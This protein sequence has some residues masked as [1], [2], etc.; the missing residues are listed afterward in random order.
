MREGLRVRILDRGVRGGALYRAKG[1]VVRVSERSGRVYV[2]PDVDADASRRGD[3]PAT[4][5]AAMS[6]GPGKA[7][8]VGIDRE[9]DL[10]TLVPAVGG[11]VCIVRGPYAGEVGTVAWR[12]GD[13]AQADVRVRV[14]GGGGGGGEE[15][16]RRGLSFDDICEV[17]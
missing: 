9:R 8:P 15:R 6:D 5:A 12:D 11:R 3:T 17:R 2:D 7:E 16:T 14:A 4:A 13:K 10:E 1:Y